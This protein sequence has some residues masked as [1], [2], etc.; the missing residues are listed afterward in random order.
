MKEIHWDD[1][2]TEKLW[3]YYSKISG[4][5]NISYFAYHSGQ[6]VLNYLHKNNIELS[7]KKILDFGCGNAYLYSWIKTKYSVDYT[8]IEFSHKSIKTIGENKPYIDIHHIDEIESLGDSEYDIIFALEL[9]EHLNDDY[10]LADIEVWKKLLK[11]D[12]IIIITTPNNENLLNNMVYCPNCDCRYH[13]WQH[14]R[15]WDKSSISEYFVKH[16]FRTI[17]CEETLFYSLQKERLYNVLTKLGRCI[18][19]ILHRNKANPNLIY[20]GK[21]DK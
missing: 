21:N 8:G 14:I 3:D 16:G 15:T 11:K 2:K 20:I 13:K 6:S 12:G 19:T 18:K 4:Y 5:G 7:N 1:E 17:L 9:I 10:L